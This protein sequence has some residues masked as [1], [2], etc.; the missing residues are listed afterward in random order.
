VARTIDPDVRDL[1]RWP[2]TIAEASAVGAVVLSVLV[3]A[4][5]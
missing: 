1:P 5:T 2:R 4:T 3:I